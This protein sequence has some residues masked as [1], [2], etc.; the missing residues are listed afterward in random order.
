MHSSK[1]IRFFPLYTSSELG[2]NKHKEQGKLGIVNE[3]ILQWWC[4]LP[5][6]KEVQNNYKSYTESHTYNYDYQT[7]ITHNYKPTAKFRN[8]RA[9]I[10]KYD[11]LKPK[12]L[13][14]QHPSLQ[15]F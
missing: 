14:N 6:I 2:R 9:T 13:L 12:F 8:I 10:S 5:T 3:V 4:T 11:K 15:K 7:T 1:H